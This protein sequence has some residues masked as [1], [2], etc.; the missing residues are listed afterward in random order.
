LLTVRARVVC[1]FV[2]AICI[3][4]ADAT[5]P[6]HLSPFVDDEREVRAPDAT[7]VMRVVLGV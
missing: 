5:L 3:D 7:R 1:A 4:A 6:P 2:T